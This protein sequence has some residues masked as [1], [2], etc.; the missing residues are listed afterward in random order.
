MCWLKPRSWHKA[1]YAGIFTSPSVLWRNRGRFTWTLR[2][3]SLTWPSCDPWCRISPLAL[4]GVRGPA[5]CSALS[6]EQHF[7]RLHADLVNH[8]FDD[9]AGA[10]DQVDDGK[11]D[12]TVGLAEL[13]NDGGRLAR[14]AGHDVVRF[15][16]G[17]L[18]PF[19]GLV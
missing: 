4:P 13:L 2:S 12:L 3:A 8:G 9:M 6:F 10:L 17:W 19:G 7:Q 14:G 18:V 5:T 11:Q 1:S 15:L 16:H